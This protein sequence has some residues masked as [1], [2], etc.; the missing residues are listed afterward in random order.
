MSPKTIYNWTHV[1]FIPFIKLPK[2][3]RFREAEV[4]QWLKKRQ[5]K[6]RNSFKINI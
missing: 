3:I 6:G 4:N 5:R 1:G 2:D